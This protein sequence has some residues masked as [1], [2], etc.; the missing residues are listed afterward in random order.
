M[1]EHKE[2]I[3]AR[4]CDAADHEVPTGN[5]TI[6][7]EVPNFP[8]VNFEQDYRT[9]YDV[10]AAQVVDVLF[11]CLP[12]ATLDRVFAKFAIKYAS[13]HKICWPQ[14]TEVK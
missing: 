12:G 6:T 11:A 8:L 13:L 2:A 1:R 9:Y 10:Q 4:A 14:E 5:I 7:D 3:V